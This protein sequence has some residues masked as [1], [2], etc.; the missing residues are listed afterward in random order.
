MT[1]LAKVKGNLPVANK[2]KQH[3]VRANTKL[4]GLGQKGVLRK[5]LQ[6]TG[7]CWTYSVEFPLLPAATE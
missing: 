2:F 5:E 7:V 3:S 6:I 4:T 1:S